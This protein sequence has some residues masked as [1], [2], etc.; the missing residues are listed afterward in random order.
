MLCDK[1]KALGFGFEGDLSRGIHETLEL[2]H[3]ARAGA[4]G[5]NS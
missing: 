1:F 2:L 5:P 4:F 3:N